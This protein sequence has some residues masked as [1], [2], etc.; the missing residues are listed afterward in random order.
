MKHGLGHWLETASSWIDLLIC[1]M[2]TV[3]MMLFAIWLVWRAFGH[4]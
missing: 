4:W 2:P 1:G 3:L